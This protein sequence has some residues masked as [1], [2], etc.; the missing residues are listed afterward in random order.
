MCSLKEAAASAV[1]KEPTS[2]GKKSAAAAKKEAAAQAKAK[3]LAEKKAAQ[4]TNT[5]AKKAAVEGFFAARPKT[6]EIPTEII[7][8]QKR[9]AENSIEDLQAEGSK[10]SSS[11][12]ARPMSSKYITQIDYNKLGEA[13]ESWQNETL[14]QLDLE[15]EACKARKHASFLEYCKTLLPADPVDSEIGKVHPDGAVILVAQTFMGADFDARQELQQFLEFLNTEKPSEEHDKFLDEPAVPEVAQES[16]PQDLASE[17]L[18]H[19]TSTRRS[20]LGSKS[21]TCSST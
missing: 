8:P 15:A 7:L 10:S 5:A 11:S 19:Q 13:L 2:Q 12:S 17:L 16:A 14:W 1:A 21:A 20:A 9:K 6:V 3:A 18:Q 4:I